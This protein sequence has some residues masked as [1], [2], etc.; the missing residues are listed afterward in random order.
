MTSDEPTHDLQPADGGDAALDE[1][2]FAL[3]D[4]AISVQAPLARAYVA[5]LRAQRPDA[6]PEELMRAVTSRFTVLATATGAGIGGAA[7]LPGI[8][9]I[10]AMGLTVGEGLTF[11]EAAAFA[12]LAAAE[13]HGVDMRDKHTRRLVL[14]AALSGE[15]GEE[16]IARALGK[17][18]A[19]WST[20]LAGGG[21]IPSMITTQVSKYVRRRVLARSGSLWLGRLLPFGIGAVIGGV[22]ARA[23]SRSVVEALEEI[24]GGAGTIEG[25]LAP[26]PGTIDARR[27]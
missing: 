4:S 2:W 20:V 7:A 17:S 23:V 15:R 22:G 16:I 13:V 10:A 18:G 5:R 27:L 24:F 25:D 26:E 12:M 9:T 14:M 1:R 6:A 3:L 8:G 11:G 19:Q 21:M